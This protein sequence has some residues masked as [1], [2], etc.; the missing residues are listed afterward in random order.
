MIF[1][2]F[3]FFTS[4]L[5]GSSLASSFKAL[6]DFLEAREYPHLDPNNPKHSDAIFNMKVTLARKECQ[7]MNLDVYEVDNL[8]VNGIPYG[9]VS[10]SPNKITTSVQILRIGNDESPDQIRDKIAAMTRQ[11][12]AQGVIRRDPGSAESISLVDPTPQMKRKRVVG[13][14]YNRILFNV[15]QAKL[16]GELVSVSQIP[17]GG[18]YTTLDG[19]WT[20]ELGNEGGLIITGP[21]GTSSNK[22]SW[23]KDLVIIESVK[24]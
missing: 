9:Y 7:R 4:V 3:L 5:L 20:V 6:E 17:E 8:Y 15:S 19:K 22:R 23:E 21:K 24:L 18:S 2:T 16:D 11:L 12:E 1:Y 14:E 10:I 13:V